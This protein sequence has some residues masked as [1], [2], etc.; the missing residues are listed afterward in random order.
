MRPCLQILLPTSDSRSHKGQVFSD[1]FGSCGQAGPHFS[2]KHERTS[3]MISVASCGKPGLLSRSDR[4]PSSSRASS[5]H[6]HSR[7]VSE[8]I[9]LL[10]GED[11]ASQQQKM[12]YNYKRAEEPPRNADGKMTCIHKGCSGLVFKNRSKWSKHMDKHDRPYRCN[13]DGCDKS[14]G[15]TYGGGLLRHERE[16]HNM[17]GG[18]KNLLHCPYRDCKR[19]SGAGFSR[20]DNLMEH[21]RRVHRETSKAADRHGSTIQISPKRK[22]RSNSGLSDRGNDEMRAEIK[23]LRQEKE[24]TDSRLRE[25]E[26]A[27]LALQQIQDR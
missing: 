25:I 27:F 19:S 24:E 26:Q 8:G 21:L 3:S 1:T 14:Q 2:V 23:R 20:K 16:V 4:S 7:K 18:A 22:R 5:P 12:K 17:H 15:F 10:S 9:S 13:F 11:D 6:L